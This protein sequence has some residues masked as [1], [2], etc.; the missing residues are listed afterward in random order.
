MVLDFVAVDNFDFQRKIVQKKLLKGLAE[1]SQMAILAIF[2]PPFLQLLGFIL[3]FEKKRAQS[4]NMNRCL[5]DRLRGDQ[6][7]CLLQCYTKANVSAGR[8]CS[9]DWEEE[10]RR[11]SGKFITCQ[12]QLCVFLQQTLL[13]YIYNCCV[14]S[15]WPGKNRT[16]SN[17][18]FNGSPGSL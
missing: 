15:W 14:P 16:T 11:R 17:F 3:Y 5:G 8:Q 2:K 6:A 1:F 10:A 18:H 4:W 9:L 7:I 13:L 12:I